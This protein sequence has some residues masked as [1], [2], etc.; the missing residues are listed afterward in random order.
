M[1]SYQILLRIV[2][3]NL[4]MA[5]VVNMLIV[6]SHFI[7]GGS[8]GVALIIQHF[9]SLPFSWI[10]SAIN[11]IM[12]C[13]GFLFL[14]KKFAA[15]TLLSTI[16]YPFFID[17]TA[18][19]SSVEL[20]RDPLIASIMAGVMMGAGL[21]MV[22]ESGASTGGMDIPPIILERKLGWNVA[23]LMNIQD[24]LILFYQLTYSSLE[25]IICGITF[26]F[27]T[28]L[29]MNQ[30]LTLGKSS[31]QL[32]IMSNRSQEIRDLFIHTLDKGLTLF[33]IEGGYSQKENLAVCALVERKELYLV[34]KEISAI[35][36]KAF[37]I[38]SKVQEVRGQGFKPLKTI[39]FERKE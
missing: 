26:V 2:L 23:L 34:Q 17:I 18:F 7:S 32:M 3:G 35:D 28:S 37:I 19:L 9:T 1:K 10:V 5:V 29:S 21:G 20:V 36:P 22:I 33:E 15:T 8:T 30:V 12:F 27:I 4:I 39:D 24:L 11:G 31:L 25:Q 14:G 13:V 38:V 16:I 6:P